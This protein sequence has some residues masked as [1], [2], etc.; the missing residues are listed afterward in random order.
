MKRAAELQKDWREKNP[1]RS[2]DYHL[3]KHYGLALGEYDR[4]LAKQDGRCAICKT[5]EPGGQTKKNGESPRFHVD[6]CHDTGVVRGLLCHNCNVGIGNMRHDPEI[7]R[8]A[9]D[10]VRSTEAGGV[11][12]D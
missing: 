2:A 1:G 11:S 8:K 7:L 5:K 10:Y 12:G 6:H 3:R 4:M 9:I